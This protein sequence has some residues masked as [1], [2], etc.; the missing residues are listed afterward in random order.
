MVDEFT[1]TGII[2]G[3]WPEAALFR[4]TWKT[5]DDGCNV[6]SVSI[7]DP[8]ILAVESFLT[9]EQEREILEAL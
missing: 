9:D 2:R 3:C 7:A 5:L 1:R 4:L 8:G 6:S